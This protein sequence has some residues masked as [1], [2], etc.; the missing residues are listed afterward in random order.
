MFMQNL[1][2]FLIRS[3]IHQLTE[4]VVKYSALNCYYIFM[5]M[6]W[7]CYS[8]VVY[9]NLLFERFLL[10]TMFLNFVFVIIMLRHY[11]RT[12]YSNSS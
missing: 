5:L 9:T 3:Q 7:F 2:S 1:I 4:F 6:L 11:L 8:K 10:T 12:I